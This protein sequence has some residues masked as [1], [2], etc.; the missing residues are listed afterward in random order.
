MFREWVG[1][2]C[3]RGNKIATVSLRT[4]SSGKDVE[5][6]L[7]VLNPVGTTQHPMLGLGSAAPIL[8]VLYTAGA[9]AVQFC[10]IKAH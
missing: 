3:P 10:R 2:V 4:T 5:M 6:L 9:A 8:P 7:K 1:R